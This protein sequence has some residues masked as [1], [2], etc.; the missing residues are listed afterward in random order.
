M[1]IINQKRLPID[2]GLEVQ[3][4]LL[5]ELTVVFLVGSLPDELINGLSQGIGTNTSINC[6]RMAN[7]GL[8]HSYL[9]VLICPSTF[10]LNPIIHR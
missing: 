7:I 9:F 10:L 5:Y 2:S 4:D 3:N 6:D 8:G 1:A